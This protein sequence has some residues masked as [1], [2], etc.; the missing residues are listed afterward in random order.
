MARQ[1]QGLPPVLA[2]GRCKSEAPGPSLPCSLLANMLPGGPEKK[3][4]QHGQA[5]GRPFTLQMGPQ[6]LTPGSEGLPVPHTHPCC[7]SPAIGTGHHGP[8]GVP[9]D[10]GH[11][12]TL[13]LGWG[14]AQGVQAGHLQDT[15]QP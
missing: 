6:R 5:L 14:V 8:G 9:G 1:A 11:M 12:Q 15:D 3:D 4:S 7:H 2:G 10:T 13:P